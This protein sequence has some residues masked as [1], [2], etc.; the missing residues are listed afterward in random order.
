MAGLFCYLGNKMVITLAEYKTYAD[1]KTTNSDDK[2]QVTVDYVND[3][4]EKFCATKF[5]G[6]K[7]LDERHVI[8][9]GFIVLKNA[10][11]I[12]VFDLKVNGVSV[13]T[14]KFFIEYGEGL[15]ETPDLQGR[16]AVSYI[17]GYSSAP[18]GLKIPAFELVT[19]FNK[20][21]FNK[22][23]TIGATGESVAFTDPKTIPAHIRAGLELYRVL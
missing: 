15:I 11:V 19:Y 10:P 18:A 13:D 6:Q 23:Q 20:R 5:S 7:V 22:S 16:A 14:S 8:V 21:E 3:F 2:L 9:D 12:D 17:Y 4:I 1:F